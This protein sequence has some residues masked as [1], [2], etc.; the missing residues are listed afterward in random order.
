CT[1]SL[2]LPPITVNVAVVTTSFV[3]LSIKLLQTI[4]SG[5]TISRKTPFIQWSLPKPRMHS[6]NF[7]PSRKSI[8]HSGTVKLLGAN[9]RIRCLGLDHAKKTSGRGASKMRVMVS[10]RSPTVTSL[11]SGIGCSPSRVSRI[12]QAVRV[13][14]RGLRRP[15]SLS[16]D[17]RSCLRQVLVEQVERIVE[18][19]FHR[20]GQFVES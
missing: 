5:L 20:V 7:P 11:L 12:R 13:S 8:S 18:A 2:V 10:S 16:L 4:R 19:F 17:A 6:R 1:V 14:A 9:Q 3:S 15:R